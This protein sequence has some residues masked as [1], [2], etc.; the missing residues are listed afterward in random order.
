MI[1]VFVA[2]DHEVVREGLRAM[3]AAARGLTLVGEARDGREVLLALEHL[4]ADVL[5]LDLSLPR[6][7]GIEVLRRLRQSQP[8]L[9][10][11]T[12]SMYPEEQYAARLLRA[13]ASAYVSK[14]RP[15]A[16]VERAIRDVM[17]GR[18]SAPAR[19]AATGSGAPHESLSAREYQV[20]LLLLQGRTNA[21]IAAEL[22]LVPST[23]SNHTAHLKQKLG[24][25]TL[26]E[27][28][29]YAHRMGLVG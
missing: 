22:D 12:L 2:D 5:V 15:L 16:D 1:R 29:S 21:D 19:A 8:A 25:S 17:S 6:V 13:G 24:V 3:I 11:V 10:V 18:A 27:I 4:K 26:A 28:V 7:A 14:D 9:R 23:V 20:F